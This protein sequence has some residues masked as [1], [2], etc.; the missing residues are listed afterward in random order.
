MKKI[1]IVI[2]LSIASL[3][4]A[5][6]IVQN[7]PATNYLNSI[8][9]PSNSVAWASGVRY[10]L[11]RTTNGGDTWLSALGNIPSTYTLFNIWAVDYLTAN[12]CVSDG[13]STFGAIYKTT[14]GGNIWVR[15]FYQVGGFINAVFFINQTTGFAVGDPV[16]GKWTL[17]KTSNGGNSWDSTGLNFP[18]INGELGLDNSLF[19]EGSKIWFGSQSGKIYSSTNNGINWITN[20]TPMNGVQ[21]IHF[22]D[23]ATG[24]GL[25]ID[26]F[27]HNQFSLIRTINGISWS[28][29]ETVLN[30]GIPGIGGLTGTSNYWITYPSGVYKSTNDG[31]DWN[32]VFNNEGFLTMVDVTVSREGSLPRSV[33]ACRQDGKIIKGNT[34]ISN[35]I[36]LISSEVPDKFELKQNYPNPFNPTTKINFSIRNSGIV[37]LTI[38]NQA[39][40]FVIQLIN[41]YKTPGSYSVNFDG[42]NLPSGVYYYKM[43]VN[44]ISET[45][46]MILIK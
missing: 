38:Y 2:L 5:Q 23:A 40:Q 14:D 16:A 1:I 3:S 13:P 18:A 46:K 44:N 39:G 9:S 32:I 12:V 4:S 45:K 21:K 26:N 17:L 11:I 6:F 25:A 22:N 34:D 31:D 33:Y 10:Q 42:G 24:K 35:S 41:E 15:T 20:Q 30:D 27:S 19:Y 36:N 28:S 29:V 7:T 43:E 37:L 8:S